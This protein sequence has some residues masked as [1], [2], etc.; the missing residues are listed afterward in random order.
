MSRGRP[1]RRFERILGK[2]AEALDALVYATAA[3]E[4]CAIALDAREASLRLQPQS[5]SAPPRVTRSRW[6]DQGFSGDHGLLE[7]LP[8]SFGGL[9]E[10]IEERFL[11]L[12]F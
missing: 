10:P 9:L 2:R 11:F 8:R 1:E 3:R 6:L 12:I 7:R 4:G 5:S